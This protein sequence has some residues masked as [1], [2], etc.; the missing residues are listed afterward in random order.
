[1]A[2][3]LICK[4][5][6]IHSLS[7]RE[8][9]IVENGILG[10]QEDGEIAFF[11]K[12]E[13]EFQSWKEKNKD[14]LGK[15]KLL[16]LPQKI[17]IPGLIDTHVHAPQY[18]NSGTGQGVPL[19]DWLNQFTFPTEA[20]YSDEN[21]AR[22]VYTK[23]VRRAI[24]NGIT[25]SVYFSSIHLQS[26][27]VLVDV[28]RKAGSRALVG[29][30]CMDCNSPDYYIEKTEDSL[31]DTEL[32]I[33]FFLESSSSSSSSS[34]PSLK[35]SSSQLVL[36]IITP[37]FAPTCSI[38][39][40]TGVG[41]LADRHQ[42][43]IQ[44]HISENEK[45]VEWVKSLFPQCASYTDVYNKFGLLNERTIMAHGCHLSAEELLVFKEKGAGVSHCPVSN[46]GICSGML[47][48]NDAH[49]K[50]VKIGLGT[51]MSGGYSPSLLEVIRQTIITSQALFLA[52]KT[53]TPPITFKEA[54]YL[55]TVGGGQLV[56]LG[57]KL[58]NFQPGK[59]FDALVI[60]PY[61]PDSA[62]DVFEK[63][64]LLDVF[65][66]FLLI[67]DDRNIQSVFVQGKDITIKQ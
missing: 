27:K 60:D 20:K 15:E 2:L 37:R 31:Q 62:F 3:S 1:M 43:P 66:K 23:V 36:P 14:K 54:F 67:G 8:L 25:T 35:F 10:V 4:S 56:G 9:E 26:T 42:L 21:F 16:E 45:E 17:I 41:E 44:S 30:V 47:D 53:S 38:P 49:Q 7:F 33:K 24:K 58:G 6:F 5:N 39:L 65:E 40:L 51:D 12:T 48:V 19:L 22:D 29:K 59:W 11:F 55:A 61:A 32:F 18:V 63:D 34:S 57:T 52:K 28:L 13:E 50:G 46:F 64:K